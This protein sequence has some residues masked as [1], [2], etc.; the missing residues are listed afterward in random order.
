MDFDIKRLYRWTQNE[1]ASLTIQL[2]FKKKK[3]ELWTI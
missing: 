1:V 2:V 3:L